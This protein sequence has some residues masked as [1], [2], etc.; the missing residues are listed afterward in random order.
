MFARECLPQFPTYFI[1]S[2]VAA[3]FLATFILSMGLLLLSLDFR[4]PLRLTSFTSFL[5]FK[6]SMELKLNFF[7]T[8]FTS[9]TSLFLLSYLL[10]TCFHGKLLV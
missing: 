8:F 9:L 4:V 1:L 6:L 3:V 2:G 5:P 7:G 10:T